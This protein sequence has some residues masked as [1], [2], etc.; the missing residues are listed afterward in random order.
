MSSHLVDDIRRDM[1][2]GSANF[3]YFITFAK[4]VM[5]FC[6]FVSLSAS[7]ITQNVDEF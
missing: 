6:L 4:K 7:K 2:M 1:T 3:I 5:I